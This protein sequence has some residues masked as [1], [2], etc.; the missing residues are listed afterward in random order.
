MFVEKYSKSK[1]G[2]PYFNVYFRFGKVEVA[3]TD[4]TAN[5]RESAKEKAKIYLKKALDE[6]V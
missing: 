5:D 4:L 3:V 6:E 1:G 2:K